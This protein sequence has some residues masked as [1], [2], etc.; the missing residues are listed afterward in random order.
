MTTTSKLG[1]NKLGPYDNVYVERFS[2]NM[3][4]LDNAVMDTRKINGRALS[5]DITL[6]LSDFGMREM[7]NTEIDAIIND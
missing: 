1:L 6:S 5:A 7:T 4:V 2:E 3:D